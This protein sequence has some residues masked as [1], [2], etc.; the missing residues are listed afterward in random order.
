MAG[1]PESEEAAAGTGHLGR[2]SCPP[3]HRDLRAMKIY[4]RPPSQ[5]RWAATQA[6]AEARARLRHTGPNAHTRRCLGD[7]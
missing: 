3:N 5:E 4:C 2:F 7:D 1:R 6:A